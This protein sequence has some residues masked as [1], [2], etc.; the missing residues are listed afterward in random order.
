M[1]VPPTAIVP[2][3]L[4][5]VKCPI[6]SP[7]KLGTSPIIGDGCTPPAPKRRTPG[8]VHERTARLSPEVGVR[9]LIVELSPRLWS[10]DNVVHGKSIEHRIAWTR[11]YVKPGLSPIIGG[12]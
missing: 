10:V 11:P 9:P 4:V 12:G 2:L 7:G 3:T 6:L 5:I 8:L 1:L